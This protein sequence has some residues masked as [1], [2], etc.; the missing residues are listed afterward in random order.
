MSQTS[1]DIMIVFDIRD[2]HILFV[3]SVYEQWAI[4][5]E[6]YVQHTKHVWF[7]WS[8]MLSRAVVIQ[9]IFFGG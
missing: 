6:I 7:S 8:L 3:S 2:T 5:I 9:A 1:F 4:N